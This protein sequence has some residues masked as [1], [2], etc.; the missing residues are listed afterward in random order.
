MLARAMSALTG[1][2]A[3]INLLN[4]IVIVL[5]QGL[6]DR[7]VNK[8]KHDNFYFFI[9][10]ISMDFVLKKKNIKYYQFSFPVAYRNIEG[11]WFLVII[12]F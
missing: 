11:K 2:D 9:F 5:E 12:L 10:L 1:D 8:V 4:M 7:L 3:Q 6:L